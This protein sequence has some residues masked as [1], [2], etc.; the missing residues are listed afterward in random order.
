MTDI[1]ATA[2]GVQDR[3]QHLDIAASAALACEGGHFKDI[4]QVLH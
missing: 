2:D 1:T 3:V 4:D